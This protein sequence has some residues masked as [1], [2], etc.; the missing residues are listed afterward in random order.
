MNLLPMNFIFDLN[1][2]TH[3][4]YITILK[5][6]ILNRNSNQLSHVLTRSV[7]YYKIVLPKTFFNINESFVKTLFNNY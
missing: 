5:M 4:R 3:S 2:K 1:T 6:F 7:R